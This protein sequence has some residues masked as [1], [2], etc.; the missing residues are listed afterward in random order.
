MPLEPW[1]KRYICA[2]SQRGKGARLVRQTI[3]DTRSWHSVNKEG[4]LG[5]LNLRRHHFVKRDPQTAD[6]DD[7]EEPSAADEAAIVARLDALLGV[8]VGPACDQAGGA[9]P[10][11]G[12]GLG[13][14]GDDVAA[15]DGQHPA[16]LAA[17][18]R[19]DPRLQAALA[20]R[21]APRADGRRGG[22]RYRRGFP[23]RFVQ[24]AREAAPARVAAS[25]AVTCGAAVKIHGFFVAHLGRI[26]VFI[27]SQK[28]I[29]SHLPKIFISL[30]HAWGRYQT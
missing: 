18:R 13:L 2:G 10:A 29:G 12:G 24:R 15:G 11:G 1:E 26:E 19:L 27:Q 30:G 23:R 17:G 21:P 22:F 16:P 28:E 7:M 14:D 5:R 25:S 8:G 9:D 4:D 3:D 20:A 6:V